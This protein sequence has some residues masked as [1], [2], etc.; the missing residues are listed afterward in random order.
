MLQCVWADVCA[1]ASWICQYQLELSSQG[2]VEKTLLHPQW[3]LLLQL[4]TDAERDLCAQSHV[5]G[6]HS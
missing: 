1:S 5:S 3:E 2:G 6:A 4:S